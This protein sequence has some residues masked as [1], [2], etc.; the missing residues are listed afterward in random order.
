MARRDAVPGALPPPGADVGVDATEPGRR[1]NNGA[2]GARI[3]AR[4]PNLIWSVWIHHKG[5]VTQPIRISP[6]APRRRDLPAGRALASWLLLQTVWIGT[7]GCRGCEDERPYTPFTVAASAALPPPSGSN[8]PP[9][10]SASEATEA[11]FVPVRVTQASPRASS[12]ELAGRTIAAPPGQWIVAG[13]AADLSRT[14]DEDLVTWTLPAKGNGGSLWLHP[15]GGAARERWRLPGFVPAGSDCALTPV[16]AHTGP[17]TITVDVTAS[18]QTPGIA[19]TPLRS[20]AVLTP[21]SDRAEALAVRLAAP[22]PGE[23]LEVLVDSTD[24]DGDDRD[25]VR[26]ELRMSTSGGGAPVSAFFE[27][28][29]RAAGP[30]RQAREPLAS[31]VQVA[32]REL[33]RARR[34]DGC[35]TA[36][37]RVELVQRL[38]ASVCA[39]AGTPRLFDSEG[40]PLPCGD[41]SPLVAALAEAEVTASL[42]C[43]DVLRAVSVLTRD[44]WFLSP[45]PSA[46]RAAL[47]AQVEP[48][49][50]RITP[51]SVSVLVARVAPR[52]G[53]RW[54]PLR[55]EQPEPS[56]LVM[57]PAGLLRASPDGGTEQPAEPASGA[58]PWT[59]EVR[60]AAGLR[61]TSV[62]QACDRSEV[63]LGFDGGSLQSRPSATLAARPGV[64]AGKR[65]PA[66]PA[67]VPLGFLL[68]NGEEQ[69]AAAVGG[70]L[71]A[72][73]SQQSGPGTPR[74]PD[75]SRL[76][77]ATGLGVLVLG[78]DRPQLWAGAELGEPAELSDC[79]PA[80]DGEAIACVRAGR[81][82]LARR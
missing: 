24:R 20:V 63:L 67:A 77:I 36:L 66:V 61:W 59:L 5:D 68:R 53:P 52:S 3:G 15:A 57:T 56:L 29:D 18:C 81:V 49:L 60:S 7:S 26:I 48:Q 78:G 72:E 79:V 64:C 17:R 62:S 43:G 25:D 32:R 27:W 74:S 55:F 9:S 76:A 34:R 16:L 6:K 45:L 46:R 12:L 80:N 71:T 82:L 69:L 19:R 2:R 31:L 10:S 30:S 47:V 21:T 41:P 38:V 70:R 11:D 75:G 37:Q 4:R 42:T 54:S 1:S 33:D 40:S 14:G 65:V 35:E 8:P 44:G 51:R 23:K 58:A 39:E 50:T 22:A 73:L 13:L 28:I